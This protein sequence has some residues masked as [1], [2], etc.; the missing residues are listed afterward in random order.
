MRLTDTAVSAREDCSAGIIIRGN[1]MM[2]RRAMQ[3]KMTVASSSRPGRMAYKVNTAA[4][5]TMGVRFMMEKLSSRRLCCFLRVPI[6][7]SRRPMSF[8]VNSSSHAMTF[9]IRMPCRHS[10][11]LLTRSSVNLTLSRLY[12]IMFRMTRVLTGIRA[13]M[14]PTPTSDGQP[15]P[16]Y[17]MM[18]AV[19]NC[20][21]ALQTRCRKKVQSCNRWASLLIIVTSRP[22]WKS[23]C[24]WVALLVSMHF[25]NSF[26][27]WVARSQMPR[28]CVRCQYWFMAMD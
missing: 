22:L 2:F 4:A 26:R 25:W 7:F 13:A 11:M 28:R 9:T 14:R 8:W 23:G 5:T 19:R 12:L 24:S 10:S 16:M 3:G 1:R 17:S 21:G 20:S 6:S 27:I 18:Q 15:R